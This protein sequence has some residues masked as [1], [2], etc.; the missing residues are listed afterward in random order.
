MNE[1]FLILKED[2][3]VKVIAGLAFLQ[4][5][6][7]F[8][9]VLFDPILKQLGVSTTTLSKILKKWIEQGLI[10]K[11]PAPFPWRAKYQLQER[12]KME[13][14]INEVLFNLESVMNFIAIEK[15]KSDL[16]PKDG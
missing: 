5:N 7:C 10:L 12:Q 1:P 13:K 6:T 15:S 3:R 16:L 4:F 11:I 8:W 2:E 9:N 14:Y